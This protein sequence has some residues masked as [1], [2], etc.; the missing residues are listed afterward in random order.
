MPAEYKFYKDKEPE[1]W[2]FIYRHTLKSN[3]WHY[4]SSKGWNDKCWIEIPAD[5]SFL[6]LGEEL[7]QT[8]VFLEVL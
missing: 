6:T 4:I 3:K 2:D 7:K 5:N 8:G 1:T